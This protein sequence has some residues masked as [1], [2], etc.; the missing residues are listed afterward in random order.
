MSDEI[1]A[2][3]RKLQGEPCP[4][5]GSIETQ[6]FSN[7]P[8]NEKWM[9]DPSCSGQNTTQYSKKRIVKACELKHKHIDVH[10]AE[11]Q[12]NLENKTETLLQSLGSEG[13]RLEGTISDVADEEKL[14]IEEKASIL[15]AENKE[16][17]ENKSKTLSEYFESEG[18]RLTGD[19]RDVAD[20]EK[21]SIQEK[22]NIHLVEN[23]ERL[24]NKSK[25]LSEYFESEGERL[26]GDLRDVAD[27]EKIS[28]QEKANIHLIENQM[29]LKNQFQTLSENLESEGNRWTKNIRD[30]VDEEKIS[31][32]EIHQRALEGLQETLVEYNLSK[33]SELTLGPFFQKE[34]PELVNFYVPPTL[35]KVLPMRFA[36][37]YSSY[38]K[39]PITSLKQLLDRRKIFTCIT[40][41]AG[42]G[43]TSF[44]KFLARLWCAV[45]KNDNHLLGEIQGKADY[46]QDVE[47]LREF[48]YLFSVSLKDVESHNVNIENIIFS[49]L[50]NKI[51]D[52]WDDDENYKRTLQNDLKEK[53]S[54]IILDGLD[55]INMSKIT[56]PLQ[57]KK[58]TIICT[59]RPWKLGA[60]GMSTSTYTEIQL[61]KMDLKSTRNLLK[62]A[63]VCLNSQSAIKRDI[64]A[65]YTVLK[66]QNLESLLPNPLIALQLLCIYHDRYDTN[67]TETNKF[68]LGKTRTHVYA[69]VVD[70]MLKLAS[71]KEPDCFKELCDRHQDIKI[72]PRGFDEAATCNSIPSFVEVLES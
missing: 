41:N 39:E 1:P 61:E 3:R 34:N 17:L 35:S 56:A 32:K 36:T 38:K 67:T 51:D 33:N 26:T 24:E 50:R 14:S 62:H 43:K 55:E 60:M 23:Q 30:V 6:Y 10:L 44:C 18:E 22:A 63:N 29:S 25:T 20:E 16:S 40:S 13:D 28:I 12:E 48:H 27:E 54:L 15:L 49:H 8:E 7:Y 58:Y 46:L 53:H 19:L 21:I 57:S 37:R 59:C 69:N 66:E 11:N 70:M 71:D 9:D 52:T 72:L 4:V 45:K 65:F 68:L 31:N 64:D 2:K 47:F 5:D 42:L